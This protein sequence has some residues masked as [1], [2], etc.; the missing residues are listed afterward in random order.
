MAIDKETQD[1]LQKL[2]VEKSRR[3][4]TKQHCQK[5]LQ[6]I[7][8]YDDNTAH[9]AVWEL[10]Q[11]ARDL[12]HHTNIR[13]E[14]SDKELL[15]AHNGDSFTFDSL[16][17]LVKQVSSE[18]KEDP[19]AAGQFGTGFMTTHK[20]SRLLHINGSYEVMPGTYVAL[21]RF[22]ID[23]RPNDLAGLRVKMEEQLKAVDD[24][25]EEETTTEKADWTEF[26]YDL[27]NDER[28]LAANQGVVSAIEL[29]PYVMTINDRIEVCTIK[30]SKETIVFKKED[31]EDAEGLHC[32]CIMRNDKE[33]NVYYLQSEDGKDIIILPL[34]SAKEARP[35]TG[36]PRLFIWFPLLG[37]EKHSINY[38]FHSADFY[39]TEPR[40]LIVLPDGNSEHQEKI[41]EDK[42]V[43]SR[44]C[45]MLFD[46]LKEHACNIKKSIHL[47][48][49]GFDMTAMKTA[50]VEYLTERHAAWINEF[51]NI[52]FIEL[53]DAHYCISQTD[54]VRVLDHNIVEFLR[55]EGN[56]SHLDIVY[57]YASKVSSLPKKYEVLDW[58][59]IVYQWNPEK[60]E[61]FVT[62]KDIVSQITSENDKHELLKFLQY[63]KASDQ[64]SLYQNGELIPN[65]E[66]ELKR[67]T[68]LRNGK[69]S[70]P[71]NLYDVINP[72][73]PSYTNL[74]VDNDFLELYDYAKETRDG[75]KTAL[76]I[77]LREIDAE[78]NTEPYPLEDIVKLCLTFPTN[79]PENN[80]RYQAMKIICMRFGYSDSFNYVPHLGDV[81]KEQLMYRDVFESL[82]RYTFKQI[83]VESTQNKEWLTVDGN[84]KFLHSLLSA[85]CNENK[86]SYFQTKVMPDYAIFPNQ[87]GK[88]CQKDDLVV[89]VQDEG[90]A[91]TGEDVNDL[92]KY[93][94]D[95]LSV[96]MKNDW[97]DDAYA[98][99][100]SFNEIKLKT[101]A[102]EI[103]EELSKVNYAPKTTIEII[104]HLDDNKD[105]WRYWFANI[106][107]NKA[108]VFLNRIEDVTQRKH[109][110]SVMKSDKETLETCAELCDM[111]NRK[112]ILKKLQG[113][114]Q[115]EHDN[116]ARFYHLHTIGKHIEDTLRELI[117]QD[118]VKVEKRETKDDT[119]IVD[120]IQNGQDIVISVK[121]EGDWKDVYY[122][123]VKSK[124]DFNE[125]A[126]MSTRQV[127][128]AALHPKNYALCCVDLRELK[129]EELDKLPEATIAACTRVK[130]DIG[131]DLQP[132]VQAILDADSLDADIQIK[133]SE[134]RSNMSA[135]VFEKGDSLDVLLG[136]IENI[137]RTNICH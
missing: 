86:N 103:D 91:H 43:V 63:L 17:S 5:I 113:L 76:N 37:T 126:H 72:L 112:D 135:K 49:V 27:D 41:N 101:K 117:N 56:E 105:V 9:R 84:A 88:L 20:F 61:W 35:M 65:R 128:M 132:L 67:A 130:M 25:L 3:Q 14:L 69:E 116:Q 24:L 2:N 110:Y 68:E 29:M 133:I 15:F 51:Q 30:T 64:A 83:E 129:E 39:P 62:V 99:F 90:H 98:S 85:L 23:R 40:D 47:A 81:D 55:G 82:V 54:K 44:M 58:S 74:L 19:E 52:P 136:K 123:E 48:P 42:K 10:V 122:V 31:R 118:L 8:K 59:D 45:K 75:L 6:G 32:K 80:D 33:I 131:Q 71:A 70:I 21:N 11:N 26:I 50:T 77:R 79:N 4:D 124:W 119:L 121:D 114:I 1:K 87:N 16:S 104:T 18:E 108:K 78:D 127:R 36:I 89:V 57:Q 120:D 111:P 93:Y 107:N 46:Y 96:D 7:G 134:Y 97:V 13:I 100:Q 28:K 38:I 60:T 106:D 109:I 94:K 12:S 125:P 137:V 95:V 53:D 66:G 34:K 102:V 115:V 73:V 22:K 92:C